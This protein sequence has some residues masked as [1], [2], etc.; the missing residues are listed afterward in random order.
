MKSLYLGD[1]KIV[2]NNPPYD[3]GTWKMY[4][5]S[6]DPTESYDLSKGNP[7][8]FEKMK[9]MYDDYAKRVGVVPPIGFTAPK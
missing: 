6:N 1:W 9:G 8:L 2:M 4:D 3:D 7:V 5:M